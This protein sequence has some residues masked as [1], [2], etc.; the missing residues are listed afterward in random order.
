MLIPLIP[1]TKLLKV[2]AK[3]YGI[4]LNIMLINLQPHLKLQMI[5]KSTFIVFSNPKIIKTSTSYCNNLVMQSLKRRYKGER[6]Q[7]MCVHNINL[8]EVLVPNAN[9]IR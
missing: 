1:P 4:L 5:K 8:M 2:C 6:V 7:D 9:K 3:L